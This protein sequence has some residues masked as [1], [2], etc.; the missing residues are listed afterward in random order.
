[1]LYLNGKFKKL[2]LIIIGTT[3]LL[4]YLYSKLNNKQYEKKINFLEQKVKHKESHYKKFENTIVQSKYRVVT[5]YD[6]IDY[7]KTREGP[8]EHGTAY[9]LTNTEDL[10]HNQQLYNKTGFFA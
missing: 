6:K 10:K 3:V 1:M 8:G 2:D 7:E 4:L 9:Y 5:N